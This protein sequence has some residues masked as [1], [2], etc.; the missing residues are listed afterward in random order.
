MWIILMPTYLQSFIFFFF[1]SIIFL[2]LEKGQEQK[3]YT[4]FQSK[5]TGA[6]HRSMLLFNHLP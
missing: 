6:I 5:K 4:P 3:L 1:L 2:L